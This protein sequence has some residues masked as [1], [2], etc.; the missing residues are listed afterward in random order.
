MNNLML[1]SV[2]LDLLKQM[3]NLF[4]KII[5]EN[6]TKEEKYKTEE[7]WNLLVKQMNNYMEL[8][9]IERAKSVKIEKIKIEKENNSIWKNICKIFKEFLKA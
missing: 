2:V 6:M 1:D 5:F 8:I 4:Y 9:H 7:Q 3:D